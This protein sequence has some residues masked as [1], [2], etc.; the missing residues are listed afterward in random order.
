MAFRINEYSII[1]NDKRP[2]LYKEM[3]TNPYDLEE[4]DLTNYLL[5]L[6][7]KMKK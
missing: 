7:I 2:K 5:I 1:P 3:Q 6:M 4:L